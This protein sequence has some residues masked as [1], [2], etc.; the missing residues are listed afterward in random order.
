VSSIDTGRPLLTGIVSSL[1][2]RMCG[3]TLE[4]GVHIDWIRAVQ[5]LIDILHLIGIRMRRLLKF[6]VD[7]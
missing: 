2:G 3:E 4:M 1:P 6:L 5:V 7:W